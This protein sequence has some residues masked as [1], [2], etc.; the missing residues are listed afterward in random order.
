MARRTTKAQR[1]L[2]QFRARITALISE[3]DGWDL[4]EHIRGWLKELLKRPRAEDYSPAE[5]A[6][7]HRII[8]A[9]TP[10]EGWGGFSVP[11]LI[12]A[13]L[14]Y[15]ADFGYDDEIFLK[16]LAARNVTQLRLGDMGSLVGLCRMA[17]VE[18][19]R[20]KPEIDEYDE[21]A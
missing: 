3:P 8:A 17:G 15:A 19:P 21:A 9:R 13:A 4:Y 16:D 7:V 18:L 12:K 5:R 11:E 6:A 2:D 1:E 20:F 14:R 10:F